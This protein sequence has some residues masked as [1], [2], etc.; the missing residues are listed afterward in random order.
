MDTAT[1]ERSTATTAPETGATTT[2][3]EAFKEF[4]FDLQG[5]LEDPARPQATGEPVNITLTDLRQGGKA[6]LAA[7]VDHAAPN[8]GSELEIAV[9][10]RC[11]I[12][13]PLGLSGKL[14]IKV[15]RAPSGLVTTLLTGNAGV[16]LGD[17]KNW[18]GD[19][20][21][22][23]SLQGQGATAARS[24]EMLVLS[25]D[26]FMRSLR[27]DYLLGILRLIPNLV[28][29]PQL[30]PLLLGPLGAVLIAP[31]IADGLFGAGS[32]DLAIEG[33][34][35]GETAQFQRGG[36]LGGAG[37]VGGEKGAPEFSGE[38][39]AGVVDQTRIVKKNGEVTD[40][41]TAAFIAAGKVG[42][43]MQSVGGIGGSCELNIY[44]NAANQPAGFAKLA[45]KMVIDPSQLPL[46]EQA[47]GTFFIGAIAEIYA[48]LEKVPEEQTPMLGPIP[49]QFDEVRKMSSGPIVMA[50]G[51]IA[52]ELAR[53]E[54][55]K[56]RAGFELAFAWDFET[57]VKTIQ[58]QYVASFEKSIPGGSKVGGTEKVVLVG[59]I[60]LPC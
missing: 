21:Q 59:P 1:A 36:G 25:L 31:W 47:F 4:G 49:S 6:A 18:F 57:G 3:A 52:G 53:R 12:R 54:L 14:S 50:A 16:S 42:G 17:S 7:L 11:P 27:E 40:Q 13:P 5:T 33:M 8:P 56:A 35:D 44:P 55:G 37:K 28:A 9:Q 46:A 51:L 26:D 60:T 48:W 39:T 2:D 20:L 38:G 19:L 22:M 10:L 24:F 34:K 45:G 30:A 32:R 41:R 43:D 58:F 15:T 23:G 29:V